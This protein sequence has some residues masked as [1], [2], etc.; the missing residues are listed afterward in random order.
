MPVK[1]HAEEWLGRSG[2][3]VDYEYAIAKSAGGVSVV[4]P[5]ELGC[6]LRSR[7]SPPASR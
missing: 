6:C 7:L 2:P 1:R 5:A 4:R 3:K